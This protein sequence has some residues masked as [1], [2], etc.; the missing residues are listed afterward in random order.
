MLIASPCIDSSHEAHAAIRITPQVMAIGQ[1]AG[2]AATR[3]VQQNLASTRDVIRRRA[4]RGTARAGS[5]RLSRATQTVALRLRN[6][7]CLAA[8]RPAR[9]SRARVRRRQRR[10]RHGEAPTRPPW[11]R[12]DSSAQAGDGPDRGETLLFAG[13]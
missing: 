9:P 2:T 1:A 3:C 5:V 12:R 6:A 8:S 7:A 13:Y 10:Q 4:P 11:N